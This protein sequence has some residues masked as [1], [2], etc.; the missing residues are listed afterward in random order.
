ML[1]GSISKKR[2]EPL[3]P[4]TKLPWLFVSLLKG[5]PSTTNRGWLEPL[6]ELIPLIRILVPEPDTPL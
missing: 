3:L 5:T 4:S 6:K 1:F 2:L